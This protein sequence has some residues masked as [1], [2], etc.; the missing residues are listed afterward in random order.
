MVRIE[1]KMLCAQ[2]K[3]FSALLVYGSHIIISSEKKI[4][5][6]I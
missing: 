2:S 3:P 6:P 1:K 5:H 4:C